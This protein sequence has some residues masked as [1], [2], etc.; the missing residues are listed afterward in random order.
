MN[1]WHTFKAEFHAT[2]TDKRPVMAS[3]CSS[4]GEAERWRRELVRD[5]TKKIAA[6]K[7]ASLG[8]H[9]IRELND[10]INKMMRQKRHWEV[11]IKELGGNVPQGK[12]YYDI[13]GKELPG[14]PGYKYYGAARDLPGVRELFSEQGD[15][16]MQRKV[17]KRSRG[18][19]HK[20][21]T[22]DYYGYRDEDDG[23][24]LPLEQQREREMREESGVAEDL[25]DE[26]EE[27]LQ[28][29]ALRTIGTDIMLQHN[30]SSPGLG[31]DSSNP[32]GSAMQEEKQKLEEAL[33]EKKKKALLSALDKF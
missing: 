3:D 13:E 25:E 2:G 6:I 24:L 20:H 31:G 19:I 18:E 1:K 17:K 15:E 30:S 8:E 4:V 27:F 28:L 11:R 7:N 12:Q 16:A 21:I 10:E 9:R 32:V 29:Q 14:A 33:M 22:P 26:D 23:V 5:I